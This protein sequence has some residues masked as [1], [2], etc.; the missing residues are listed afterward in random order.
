MRTIWTNGCFDIVHIGHIELF[1]FAKSLGDKLIVG[2]DSDERIKKYKYPNNKYRPINDQNNRV[3]F[4][5][6][7]K[8]IDD[9]IIFNNH[10]YMKN[11]LIQY[12]IDTIVVGDD[13]KNSEVVGEDI[14]KNIVFFPKILN[15]SSSSIIEKMI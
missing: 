7:I 1:K 3:K 10:E 5:Q 9:V 12:K 11:L 6:S 14:V 8:Y 4:L 2:I 15:K 13:Y